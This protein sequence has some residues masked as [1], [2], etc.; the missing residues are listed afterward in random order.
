[1]KNNQMVIG[2]IALAIVTGGVGFWGGTMYSK[3]RV[4]LNF[5]NRIGGRQMMQDQNMGKSFTGNKAPA[6]GQGSMGR[7]ATT[8]EVTAKDDKSI[9]IKMNDGSSRIVIL[10][11]KT[12]YRISDSSS[13]D[14][15]VVG[16][17]VAAFGEAGSDGS[18]T[19]TSIEI[20]PAMMGIS[21]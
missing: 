12:V 14:K 10:S 11:D 2:S 15:I 20:N 8:G 19:A 13:L 3:S 6:N 5:Q 21:K 18:V 1:M 17:K 9:T 16:T 7:G 4:G